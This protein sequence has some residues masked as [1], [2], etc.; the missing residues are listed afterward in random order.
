MNNLE[1]RIPAEMAP[2]VIELAS[3]LYAEQDQN[4]SLSELIEAGAEAKIPS[5]F[6]RQAVQQI[7]IEQAQAHKEQQKL[8]LGLISA[9]VATT[10]LIFLLASG[11]SMV[12]GCHSSVSMID[13]QNSQSQ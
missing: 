2:K 9:G 12:S 10:S 13:G 5:Q 11:G 6:I 3:R 8:K 4:Y 1:P 7:Q